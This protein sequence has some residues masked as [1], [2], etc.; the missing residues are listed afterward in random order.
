MQS[1]AT[2][3]QDAGE[4]VW[5]SERKCGRVTLWTKFIVVLKYIAFPT[6]DEVPQFIVN[7]C[8]VYIC[9]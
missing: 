7:T 4:S 9:I 2:K 5:R 8:I 3:K 1:H 6:C